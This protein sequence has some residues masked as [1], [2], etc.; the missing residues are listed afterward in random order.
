M[1]HKGQVGAIPGGGHS[2][3]QVLME[4]ELEALGKAKRPVRLQ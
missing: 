1:S 4:E 3:C 2:Q